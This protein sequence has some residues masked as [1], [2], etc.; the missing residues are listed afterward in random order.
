MLLRAPYAVALIALLAQTATACPC[1]EIPHPQSTAPKMDA[2]AGVRFMDTPQY[3]AE[4]DAAI[5]GAR[6]ACEKH[7]GEA[8]LAVVADIDETLLNNR[9]EFEKHPN[10]TWP[11]F[12]VWIKQSSAAT[13][14]PT[15]EF[16]AWA[17][18]QG[19]AIFLITG[20]DEKLRRPT[21]VNLVRDGVGY[22]GLYMR[23]NDDH[24]AA[25]LMKTAYRQQIER[26]GFKIV[27][28]I[29]DQ[30]SDLFGGHA[31]DCEKLPNRI[32]YIP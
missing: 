3:K 17:R 18:D 7:K 21:I 30:Y 22:D 2:Q 23:A 24:R 13:L 12:N 31:E 4:F 19:Y 5:A 1:S 14:K 10:S 16:L 32:Y 29:G 28:S 26:L 9:P 27:V 15:A 8:N 25:E 6:A 20:R 11:Q